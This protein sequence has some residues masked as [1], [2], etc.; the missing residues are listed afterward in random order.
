MSIHI[1]CPSCETTLK[2]PGNVAGKNVRCPKCQSVLACPAATARILPASTQKPTTNKPKSVI[3]PPVPSKS[4]GPRPKNLKSVPP[5]V[6]STSASDPF[7]FDNIPI[8]S[9]A[10]A[11]HPIGAPATVSSAGYYSPPKTSN[12]GASFRVFLLV[13]AG[14]LGAGLC[15]VFFGILFYSFARNDAGVATDQALS[16]LGPNTTQNSPTMRANSGPDVFAYTAPPNMP[17]PQVSEHVLPTSANAQLLEI[18]L[19]KHNNVPAAGFQTQIRIYKPNSATRKGSSTCVLVGPAGTPLLHGTE[20]GLGNDN[21]YHDEA[22]PYVRKGMIVVQFS[23][24]GWMPA[25]ESLPTE[26]AKL[27]RLSEEMAKF[28]SAHAGVTNARIAL[29]Y[30]LKHVPEIDSNRIYAAGHSSAG[31]LALQLA[32]AEPRLAGA[33]AYAPVA[34]LLK[35]LGDIVSEPTIAIQLP[36]LSSYITR[37]NPALLEPACPMFVFA[38][39][40]DQNEPFRDT[41]AYFFKVR[42]KVARGDITFSETA[43]GGHYQSM[44]DEGIPR[45]IEWILSQP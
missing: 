16:P 4:A 22:L 25:V 9:S 27:R 3:R 28:V 31:T 30:A 18:D 36:G 23:L 38:A 19:G 39:K 13:V 26:S 15:V 33:L 7:D 6:A 29:D 32:T 37:Y 1:K 45:G 12:D 41:Q 11:S 5:V 20:L 24:D 35:R 17:A 10:P 40:N 21:D 14:V 2:V 8:G 42:S 34:D 43:T 44:I